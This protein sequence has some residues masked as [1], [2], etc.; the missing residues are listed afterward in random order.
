MMR[1]K[2]LR[3]LA[4]RVRLGEPIDWTAE[5]NAMV[6]EQVA[7]DAE[8]AEQIERRVNSRIADFASGHSGGVRD[9]QPSVG[10]VRPSSPDGDSETLEPAVQ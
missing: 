1:S 10:G 3:N 7:N 9:L 5:S 2:H 8:Y 6:L 4:N